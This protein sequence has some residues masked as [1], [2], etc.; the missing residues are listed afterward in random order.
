MIAELRKEMEECSNEEKAKLYQRFFK[1]GPGQY[2]EGDVFMGLTM[3]ET[4]A[5]SSK[6]TE[7]PIEEVQE[8]LNSEIHEHRMSALL[9]VIQKYRKANKE[10]KR[11]LYEFYLKNMSRINNW[12]LIDVTA[13]HVVGDFLFNNKEEKEM[14]YKLAKS[15]DLWE[16]RISVISTFRF[17]KENEFEDSI[18]IS[19]ILLNDKHDLIH[20]AVGW[21]LREIGKKDQEIEEEFLR[22]YHKTM[23]RTMLRYSLEKFTKDK[24]DF[25][26]GRTK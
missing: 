15:N 10:E 2:G 12:D 14:L 25:Y 1:T 19:E 20:K 26:M 22:K 17:I 21:M 24:K 23:P 5:I 7:M 4:R 3:P 6:Y 13:S 16:K 11:K 9:I 18:N 8:L